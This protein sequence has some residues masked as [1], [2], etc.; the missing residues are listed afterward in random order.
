MVG[1]KSLGKERVLFQRVFWVVVFLMC[2]F[3]SLVLLVGVAWE[4]DRIQCQQSS[5]GLR[6]G[7]TLIISPVLNGADSGS[8]QPNVPDY[9]SDIMPGNDFKKNLGDLKQS[10]YT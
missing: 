7:E 5:N 10:L 1:K 3:V 4:F 8:V 9:S 2:C 6:P